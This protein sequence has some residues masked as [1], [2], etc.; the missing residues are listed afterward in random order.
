[1][2][3]FVI[4]IAS[5]GLT[6]SIGSLVIILRFWRLAKISEELVLGAAERMHLLE[7]QLHDL[8][9]ENRDLKMQL[10]VESAGE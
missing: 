5:R 9:I 6:Q 4:D 8:Q 3:S 1:M 7:F 2:L 10:G